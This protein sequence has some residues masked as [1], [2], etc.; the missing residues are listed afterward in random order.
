MYARFQLDV[1]VDMLTGLNMADNFFAVFLII[2][3][4][5]VIAAT[6]QLCY[7]EY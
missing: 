6:L 7:Y 2:L 3:A 5:I 4:L 1:T